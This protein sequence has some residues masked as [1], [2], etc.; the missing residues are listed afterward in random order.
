MFAI[1]SAY[2]LV[3][4]LVL[5]FHKEFRYRLFG[6]FADGYWCYKCGQGI[7]EMF[8]AVAAL[9]VCII[10]WWLLLIGLGV[11]KFLISRKTKKR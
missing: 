4:V 11:E 2:L 7:T 3:T 5:Y 9:I 10:F 6:A 1:I 8:R